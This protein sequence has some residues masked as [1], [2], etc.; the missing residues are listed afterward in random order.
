M[1]VSTG[2]PIVAGSRAGMWSVTGNYLPI[3]DRTVSDRPQVARARVTVWQ[4]VP[5]GHGRLAMSD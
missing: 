5:G 3:E 1:I 2:G 4:Q